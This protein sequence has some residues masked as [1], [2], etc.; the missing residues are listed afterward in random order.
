MTKNTTTTDAPD[1]IRIEPEDRFVVLARTIEAQNSEAE[2]ALKESAVK[3]ARFGDACLGQA[4]YRHRSVFQNASDEPVWSHLE[5]S[6]F[7]EMVPAE[8]TDDLVMKPQPSGANLLRAEILLTT[9]AS[10]V[11]PS[12][13]QGAGGRPELQASL[14]YIDVKPAYL[15]EYRDVMRTYC[16][17]AAQKLVGANKVGTFRAMETAAVL[18]HDPAFKI[19]WNQI[20]LCEL[21]PEGFNGFGEAF[22]AALRDDLPD[23]TDIADA[24]ADLERMRTVPRWTFNDLVVEADTALAREGQAEA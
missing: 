3:G 10:F 20:H 13:W 16:G 21:E 17:P 9:P 4:L 2:S 11:L 7:R 18:Y 6:Y 8:V 15:S 1:L 14:E 12:D 24:F 5:L 22:A 19:E 23:G